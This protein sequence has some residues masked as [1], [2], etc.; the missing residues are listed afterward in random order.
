MKKFISG[1]IIGSLSI[2][3]WYN[4]QLKYNKILF[5]CLLFIIE[6]ILCPLF[7][8]ICTGII[9]LIIA[10][11]KL[12]DSWLNHS[13]ELGFWSKL[14]SKNEDELKFIEQNIMHNHCINPKELK[15]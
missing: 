14:I 6:H 1:L 10:R 15:K 13:H 5:N 3:I 12:I 9:S 4:W 8:I 2:F 7:A 11:Y